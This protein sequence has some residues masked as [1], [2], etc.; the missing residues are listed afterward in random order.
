M[1]STWDLYV[2]L[3]KAF[4]QFTPV[5]PKFYWDVDSQEQRIKQIC[6]HIDKIIAY[7]NT[8]GISI[9]SN[10]DDIEKLVKEFE[11]FKSGAYDDYYQEIIEKWVQEHMEEIMEQATRM[12]FFG[13]TDDGY[14]CAY[15]PESWD[16]I[17]FDTGLN[18][19]NKREYG[20]LLLYY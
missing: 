16:A 14:F 3:Y 19:E 15:V 7:A 6:E 2:P 10:H 4:T 8:M 11:E 17:Q 12:V 5:I 13:L 18:Y 1:A 9:N 20:R